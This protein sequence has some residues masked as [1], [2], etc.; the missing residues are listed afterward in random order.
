[1]CHLG[2]SIP[3]LLYTSCELL[4]TGPAK[5]LGRKIEIKPGAKNGI[6]VTNPNREIV[7]S[8]SMLKSKSC[9]TPFIGLRC[10]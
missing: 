5:I 9:N 8:R 6:A 1:M 2:G 10:V 3:C 7:V 4:C